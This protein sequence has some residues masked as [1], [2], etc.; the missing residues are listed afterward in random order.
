MWET[1]DDRYAWMTQALWV[2]EG[3]VLPGPAVEYRLYRVT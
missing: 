1:G 2:G 3:R